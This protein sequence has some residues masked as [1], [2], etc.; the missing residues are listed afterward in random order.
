M[1]SVSYQWVAVPPVPISQATFS[2]DGNAVYASFVDGTVAVFDGSSLDPVCRINL[3][4]CIY[5]ALRS[6]FFFLLKA[7]KSVNYI[8]VTH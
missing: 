8:T 6:S 5:P 2:C 4:T 1:L 7:R 3:T